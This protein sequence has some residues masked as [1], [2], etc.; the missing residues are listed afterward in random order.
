MRKLFYVFPII[1]G[2]FIGGCASTPSNMEAQKP[3]SSQKI[4]YRACLP[5]VIQ[6]AKEENKGE[7]KLIAHYMCST[8]AA[9]CAEEPE[10]EPC[11][12][13]LSRF[14]LELNKKGDSL[15]YKAAN[16]GD[17]RIVET[18]INAGVNVDYSI[19]GMPGTSYGGGW[20]P[21]MIAA[22][23]GNEKIAS[24]LIGSGASVDAKNKLGRTSLM[25]ASNYGYYSIAKM[26]LENGANPDLIPNDKDG[27]PS[28]IVASYKGYDDI[29]S[30]LLSHGAN[31]G[32]RDKNG[33]TA[34]MWAENQGNTKV[35]K[36]LKSIN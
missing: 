12:R 26:L 23:E 25:F 7:E 2:L 3:T 11:P 22:A 1:S 27:W 24:V 5:W 10:K 6:G 18:M 17:Y 36:I 34:L 33:K 35:V 29:V 14:E 20:T 15:I 32:L 16:I 8:I 28:I 9:M 19:K 21:L 30:L 31:K 4:I 13:D